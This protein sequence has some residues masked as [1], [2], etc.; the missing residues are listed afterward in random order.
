MDRIKM[1]NNNNI[2]IT[3]NPIEKFLMIVK[4]FLIKKRKLILYSVAVLFAVGMISIIAYIYLDKRSSA[5]LVK[6][7]RIMEE[8][9]GSSKN[10]RNVDSDTLTKLIEL[11]TEARFGFVHDM[12]SFAVGNIYFSQENFA[13][14]RKL[15]EKLASDTSSKLYASL[16]LLKAGN[17]CEEG[18]DFRDALAIYKKLEK[19]YLKEPVADD[20]YHSLGRIY[21]LLGE[22]TLSRKYY[23]L[24]ISNFPNSFF[25]ENAKKHI[26][27]VKEGSQ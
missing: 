2:N 14:A 5:L 19:D 25:A 22:A 15:F 24:V 7:E 20:I 27:L 1:R 13:E 3:R 26:F 9:M 23:E 4:N 10:L 8:Y 18:G 11:R 6:Y 17:A 12:A 21:D 16:A